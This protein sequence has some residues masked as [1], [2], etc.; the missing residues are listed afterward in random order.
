[1]QRG[2]GGF[3]ESFFW[4]KFYKESLEPKSNFGTFWGKEFFGKLLNWGF[5]VYIYLYIYI[6]IY[7]SIYIYILSNKCLNSLMEMI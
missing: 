4:G 6:S 2:I 1:M 5:D 3:S 7:I